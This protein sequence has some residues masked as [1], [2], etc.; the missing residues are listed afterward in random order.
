[1]MMA[2]GSA[3]IS[4]IACSAPSPPATSR[5]AAVTPS[6]AAQNSRCQTGDCALPRVAIWSITNAPESAD[7][8]KNTAISTIATIDSSCG[9]GRKSKKRNSSAS[10]LVAVCAS[11]PAAPC[12]SSQIALLPNTVI[13]TRLNAVGTSS[14]PITNWRI[15]RPRE[16]RAMNMPTNGDHDTHHAQ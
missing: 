6:S 14:T 15:V 8:T 11:A 10:T 7:V 9:N 13:H 12:V 3:A 16:M 2:T 5:T 1:M 4:V